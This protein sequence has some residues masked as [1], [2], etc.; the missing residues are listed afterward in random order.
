MPNFISEDDI[1]VATEDEQELYDLLLKNGLTQAEEND[2]ALNL[3]ANH[4]K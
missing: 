4:E 2:L 1:E 3:A